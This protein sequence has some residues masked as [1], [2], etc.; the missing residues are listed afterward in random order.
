VETVT[1]LQSRGTMVQQMKTP[2]HRII[3]LRQQ[4]AAEIARAVGP[5]GQHHVA[6]AFGIP[7]P[8][9]SELN[10][11]KVH[12]CTMEWLIHRIHRMGGSVSLTI[13]LGDVAREHQQASFARIRQLRAENS[14]TSGTGS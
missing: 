11:G 13:T 3:A 4:I 12:R 8:R 2:D 5:L 14:A 9:M 1:H 7:Q 6:P 10:H